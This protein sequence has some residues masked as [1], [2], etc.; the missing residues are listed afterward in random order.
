MDAGIVAEI[1]SLVQDYGLHS[2]WIIDGKRCCTM[3]ELDDAIA[4]EIK[5]RRDHHSTSMI[6][7]T[8]GAACSPGVFLPPAPRQQGKAAGE[9]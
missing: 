7:T 4:H 2:E 9:R 5:Q 1:K 6:V 3:D 8:G